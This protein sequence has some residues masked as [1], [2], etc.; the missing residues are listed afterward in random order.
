MNVIIA[1]LFVII[2]INAAEE[3]I[4][5]VDGMQKLSITVDTDKKLNLVRS[6]QDEEGFDFLRV[7]E[8]PS[9]NGVVE[10]YV[11]GDKVNKFKGT[12]KKN[13]LTYKIDIENVAETIKKSND[14]NHKRHRRTRRDVHNFEHFPKYD[15]ITAYLKQIHKEHP[16]FT[17][18]ERI[19]GSY[20]NRDI[21]AIK[22]SKRDRN[23]KK[24]ILLI[25]A[26]IHAREWISVTTAL[27]AI[28]QLT[29]HPNFLNNMDVYVI[30]LLNPDGYE[31]SHGSD[32]ARMWRKSRSEIKRWGCTGVDLNR[33]FGF[34]WNTVG[35]SKV[36]CSPIYAGPHAFS[37]PESRALR[38]FMLRLRGR[39]KVYLSLHCP[40][41]LILHP[42][43]YTYDAPK[44]AHDLVCLGREA[45]NK[46][47]KVRKSS[48][49]VGS[50]SKVVYLSSGSS[51][52]W[53][54]GE[55]GVEMA[56]TIELTEKMHGFTTPTSEIVPVG[57]EFF[58]ALKVF[59]SHVV[60]KDECHEAT[61]DM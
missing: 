49:Q 51:T 9:K 3:Y 35:A 60:G 46:L 54:M 36:P 55:G 41:N 25:D 44:N 52:D 10:L 21:F 58:E 27:Y 2:R 45:N 14:E 24:P 8:K 50:A 7:P 42:W 15:E 16:S 1:L 22:F 56:Y 6:Y 17:K 5:P 30:P 40:G 38:D 23:V 59:S 53:A 12:L 13:H 39:I 4:P 37:E 31:F 48:Y 29:K 18:I 34:H 11:A 26:G 61:E 28:D 57:K 43:G 19:G 33:N 32:K 47:A 20:E